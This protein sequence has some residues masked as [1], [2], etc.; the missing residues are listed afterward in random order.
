MGMGTTYVVRSGGSDVA[1]TSASTA[2]EALRDYLR[3]LGCRDDEIVRMSD[4]A[5]AW[6]G[7]LYR[8][9]PATS[10]LARPERS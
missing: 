2:H 10:D 9:V 5:A 7:A 6:R 8:A 1:L 3:G 4:D